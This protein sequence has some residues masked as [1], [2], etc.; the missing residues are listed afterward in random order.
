MTDRLSPLDLSFLHGEDNDH[1]AQMHV[2]SIGIFDGPPPPHNEL[3]SGLLDRMHLIPRY[4]QRVQDVPYA[5]GRPVWV[6]ATDFDINYHVRRTALAAPGDDDDLRQLA[7]TL[8]S[9]RLDRSKPLWEIW[10]VE[11][12]AEGKWA[13]ISKVHHCMV[14]GVS[15]SE[16]MSILLD[17]T[18]DTP[19]V[20]RVDWTPR[21]VSRD[22]LTRD[23]L[24]SHVANAGAQLR[25]VAQL[26]RRPADGL[27]QAVDI[28]SGLAS[29]SSGQSLMGDSTLTGTIGAHRIISWADAS[30]SDINTIRGAFGGTVNDVVLAAVTNGFRELLASRSEPL[31]GR[32]IRCLIPVSVRASRA[33]GAASGDG[34][35]DNKV[36]AMFAALPVGLDSPTDRLEAIRHQLA[37]LKE[38]KQ[39]LAAKAL[40]DLGAH[41]PV[42]LLALGSRVASTAVISR[43]NAL[44]TVA[45]N[46]PG[47]PM[48]LYAHGRRLRRAYPYVPIAAPIRIA[49]AVFSYDGAVTF[50]VTG[51]RDTS[52]DIDVL[53]RGISAGLADLHRLAPTGPPV[54]PPEERTL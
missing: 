1:A 26:L 41:A 51:D 22:D 15:G 31:E 33:D 12:L 48:P 49:I 16:L 14:D 7:G 13:T 53:S 18:T 19:P 50:T 35:L 10:I 4:R 44:E 25:T 34:S 54:A 29:V 42:A 17:L 2:A 6:D 28:V 36:S 45:T 52:P 9:Q 38:S 27:Q 21:T 24:R 39:A 40:T 37:E 20:E 5:L 3:T 46:V 47:P 32:T 23:A 30:L 43:L 11:N 8:L